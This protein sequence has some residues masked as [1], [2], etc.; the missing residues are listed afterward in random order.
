MDRDSNDVNSRTI[1]R[2]VCRFACFALLASL[3]LNADRMQLFLHSMT[4][5]CKLARPFSQLPTHHSACQHLAG[6]GDLCVFTFFTRERKGKNGGG[7]GIE[8]NH[9]MDARA[10]DCSVLTMCC[11]SQEMKMNVSKNCLQPMVI[12][13]T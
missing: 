8:D 13:D 5:N 4:A 9:T 6:N 3:R 11:D 2:S 10:K 1:I 7:L 12:C